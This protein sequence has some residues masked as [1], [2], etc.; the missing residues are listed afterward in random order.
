[1]LRFKREGLTRF[2]LAEARVKRGDDCKFDRHVQASGRP[3]VRIVQGRRL[4]DT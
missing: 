3:K 1:M 2:Q 4:F